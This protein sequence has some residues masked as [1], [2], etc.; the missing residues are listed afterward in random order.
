MNWRR[1]GFHLLIGVVV[2]LIVGRIV[3]GVLAD[4]LWYSAHG[5]TALWREKAL[6]V[7]LLHGS[8]FVLGS[9]FVFANLYAVRSSILKLLVPR[10][11]GNV[12]FAEEVSP[13]RL[14]MAVTAASLAVGSLL[15]LAQGHWSAFMLSRHLRPWGKADEYIERDLSFYV[16]WLPVERGWYVWALVTLAST[17]VLVITLYALTT[18]LRWERGSLRV[19]R[20][21][22]RHLFALGA[23][24]LLVLAWSFRLERYELLMSGTNGG[25]TMLDHVPGL[26]VS[27]ILSMFFIASAIMVFWAGWSGQ[28]RL[29]FGVVTIC[30]V[31]TLLLRH[32]LPLAYGWSY[33]V[34]NEDVRNR[35]Y[36][37][38]RNGYTQQAFALDSLLVSEVPPVHDSVQA[39]ASRL[40]A[41]E[42]RPLAMALQ[43]TTTRGDFA[44][45]VGI[46]SH[47]G[48]VRELLLERRPTDDAVGPDQRSW[49]VLSVD[50]TSVSAGGRAPL[51]SLQPR[52][53][54]P[55]LIQEQA[56]GY[57]VVFDSSGAV[58]GPSLG[59]ASRRMVHAWATQN[60]RLAFSDLPRTARLVS[61]RDVR[62]RLATVAPFFEA[63]GS[64]AI[65][66]HNDSLYWITHL[67]AT[68]DSYPLSRA[69]N[70][71]GR[72]WSYFRYAA[73]AFVN[74]HSG[75]VVLARGQG[76]QIASTWFRVFPEL[77]TSWTEIPD[78][79]AASVPPPMESAMVQAR[80]FA[81]VGARVAPMPMGRVLWP[82]GGD[83]AILGS[84]PPYGLSANGVPQV[85][86]PLLG[87]RDD[88]L[89]GVVATSG[90][91]HPATW[92]IPHPDTTF[93]WQSAAE[94]LRQFQNEA[95]V[96]AADGRVVAGAIRVVPV[97]DAVVLAQSYYAWSSTDPPRLAGTAVLIPGEPA[98]FAPTLADAIL[99]AR[100][101]ETDTLSVLGVDSWRARAAALFD[102]ASEAL[103]R[104]DW[105]SFGEAYEALGRILGRQPL[106]P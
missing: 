91:P 78:E 60:L 10:R 21:V 44:P 26:T 61:R 34:A 33:P 94:T 75:R 31:V 79:L 99:I 95:A 3:S 7:L 92:F 17:A 73:T 9:L 82:T 59:T 56:P 39:L 48:I 6:S 83:S 90:G 30:L 22:R 57:L 86:I 70:V 101:P 96:Q 98:R 105:V 68:S 88:R 35:P 65:A 29:G 8:S 93:R 52:S 28:V 37:E 41:W 13:A 36:V 47:N 77:F 80:A 84:L 71:G 87:R 38:T 5:A 58:Q 66:V 18:S 24:L 46:T 19:T 11:V 74:A 67:Y 1:F 100:V 2:A 85:V 20:H 54:P 89:A 55:V 15:V 25:F 12:A 102:S 64:T 69:F 76:D 106:P 81:D 23:I 14:T 63:G 97:R 27:I 51:L 16:G 53:I 40:P 42:P 32:L 50:P 103:S 72:S 45:S 62:D 4:L 49:S 104:Q 43:R